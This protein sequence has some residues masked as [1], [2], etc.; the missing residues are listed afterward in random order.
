V[1]LYC[2]FFF[3]DAAHAKAAALL[4]G[5]PLGDREL[6]VS[7]K[8][9]DDDEDLAHY[10]PAELY[11][12]GSAGAKRRQEEI[13][14]T[15]Y[16]GNIGPDVGDDAL[17]NFFAKSGTVALVKL[18]GDSAG[19]GARFAFVE[20]TTLDGAQLALG[21]NGQ[22]LL[23]SVV[24]V[25][26]ANNPIFKPGAASLYLNPEDK[27]VD[28]IMQ[29]V[30]D[31]ASSI[32]AKVQEK[33]DRHKKK[34][35]RS[36]SRSGS[37]SRR[38]RRSKSRSRSRSRGRRSGRRRSRSRSPRRYRSRSPPP[39]R[40]PPKKKVDPKNDHA[41]MFFDGYRWQPI[42]QVSSMIPGGIAAIQA[43]TQA[44]AKKAH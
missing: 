22:T 26:K 37:R 2:S 33:E 24:K 29:K 42:E 21:L 28:D 23:N 31:A 36:R 17:R 20:F 10:D 44:S 9:T 38:R 39:A 13:A 11:E 7:L 35:R 15:V 34:K 43:L 32:T 16:V 30:L 4:S 14:R 6:K 40:P 3:E 1:Y 25:G 5:T 18:A 27:K 12:Q 41:G 19:K 8:Y